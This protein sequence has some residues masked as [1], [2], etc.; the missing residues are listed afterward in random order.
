MLQKHVNVFHLTWTMSLH[1][2]V[3]LEILITQ[4]AGATTALSEKETPEFIPSQLW[5]PNSPDLNPVDYS[6]WEHCK[7]RCKNTHHWSRRT[8]TATENGVDQAGSHRHCSSHSS[9][10]SSIAADQWCMFCIP[11]LQYFP[12]AV[13]NWI[14]SWR[15]WMPQLRLDKLWSFSI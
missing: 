10:A 2:L 7:R 12:H 3:K 9:V 15:I 8:E 11:I 4:V 5:P 6:V 13:I 14:Q 1:Y